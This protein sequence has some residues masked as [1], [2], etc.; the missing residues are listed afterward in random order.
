M[1]ERLR[2][3]IAHTSRPVTHSCLRRGR[4]YQHHTQYLRCAFLKRPA[5]AHLQQLEDWSVSPPEAKAAFLR[6]QAALTACPRD[7]LRYKLSALLLRDMEMAMA[8]A[9]APAAGERRRRRSSAAGLVAVPRVVV[10]RTDD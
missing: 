10:R 8:A 7:A 5:V 9:V 6:Q 2:I 4:L 1:C 3:Q